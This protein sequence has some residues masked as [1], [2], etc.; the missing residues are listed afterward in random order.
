M[1]A[2]PTRHID[3][4]LLSLFACVLF[5]TILFLWRL[6]YEGS[7]AALVLPVLI[8]CAISYG[9]LQYQLQRRRFVL[10]FYLDE[11][12]RLRKWF[13]RP[14]MAVTLSLLAAM[15]L[16]AFLAVF[17]ALSDPSDW[18]FL[19]V[20]ATAVP[21]L[22]VGAVRWPGS[23]LRQ[24]AGDG[25]LS[26]SLREVLAARIAGWLA[27]AGVLGAY[28]Y[29][30]YYYMAAPG[31]LIYPGSLERTLQAFAGRAGSACPIVADT[32]LVATRIEGLSWYLVTSMSTAPWMQDGIRPL[33][34]IVFLFNGAMA[35]GGFVRGLEGAAL[36]A[37]RA[38]TRFRKE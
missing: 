35:F 8:W 10:E 9:L 36:L 32:L 13:G 18:Y 21:L 28:I 33:L 16:T 25:A 7:C 26:P 23:H 1:S 11:G 2:L 22:F 20:A 5:L 27:L 3:R 37:G 19:C 12:S 30:G 38:A 4:L 29:F 34:W 15:S 14:S 24:N 17:V 31:D 6:S